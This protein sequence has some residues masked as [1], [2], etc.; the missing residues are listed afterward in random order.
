VL[1]L[2]GNPVSSLVTARVFLVP[3]IGRLLATRAPDATVTTARL[4][5]PL[6][7]NGPRTHYMRAKLGRAA[8][9]GLEVSPLANQDSS[10]IA[11][12]ATADALIVREAGAPAARAG[13]EVS[14]LPLD[15]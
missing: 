7:A 12:M 15:F 6:E 14:I 4:A 9:G 5:H 1:G 11:A 2:P 8:G 13:D 10:L 3:L